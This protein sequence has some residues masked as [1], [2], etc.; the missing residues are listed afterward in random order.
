VAEEESI[1]YKLFSAMPVYFM[2]NGD[3]YYYKCDGTVQKV[4]NVAAFKSSQNIMAI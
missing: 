3:V 2:E 4:D 1:Q